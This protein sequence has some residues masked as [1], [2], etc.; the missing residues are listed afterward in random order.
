MATKD[1][2]KLNEEYGA[3]GSTEV[4]TRTRIDYIFEHHAEDGTKSEIGLVLNTPTEAEKV[5]KFLRD[6]ATELGYDGD[7]K[8]CTR[9][10][11]NI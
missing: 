11:S 1:K 3:V 7:I 9:K 10:Y 2:K 6:H 8:I 5:A 4:R